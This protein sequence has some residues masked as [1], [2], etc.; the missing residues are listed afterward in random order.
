MKM[1]AAIQGVAEFHHI[2]FAAMG[3]PTLDI[4]IQFADEASRVF[5][6][7]REKHGFGASEMEN[8]CGDIYDA[9]DNLVGRVSYNGRIWDVNG[10]LVE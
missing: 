3:A 10:S 6:A 1:R 7:Y 2:H 4:S 8:G 5:S 9:A